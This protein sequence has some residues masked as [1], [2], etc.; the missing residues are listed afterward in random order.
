M[1]LHLKSLK[2]LLNK[3]AHQRVVINLLIQRW[4]KKSK[5][6]LKLLN[7]SMRSARKIRRQQAQSELILNHMPCHK[8]WDLT[9]SHRKMDGSQ[10]ITKFLI[11]KLLKMNLRLIPM[12]L[13]TI[14]TAMAL[15]KNILILQFANQLFK[16]CCRQSIGFMEKVKGLQFLHI[17]IN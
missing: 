2:R 9:S 7:K 12:S 3:R 15:M 13:R 16:N 14:L 4:N 10:K 17:R 6:S 5:S 11:I 1:S 8:M